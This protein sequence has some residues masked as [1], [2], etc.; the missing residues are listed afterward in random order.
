M[1]WGHFHN[2]QK[3]CADDP[4]S[5]SSDSPD[6]KIDEESGEG[7]SATESKG[8]KKKKKSAASNY[9]QG[10][11]TA[12]Q[13]QRQLRGCQHS[14][15][16]S[17][18]RSSTQNVSVVG[19]QPLRLPPEEQGGGGGGGGGGE[20][21]RGIGAASP[22]CPSL[23]PPSRSQLLAGAQRMRERCWKSVLKHISQAGY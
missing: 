18:P 2:I 23:P 19:P 17:S 13:T 9:I 1:A 4:F 8:K 12:S 11:K 22:T 14:S 15:C 10:G 5:I 21:R 20:E 6:C 16:Y 3:K 7:T